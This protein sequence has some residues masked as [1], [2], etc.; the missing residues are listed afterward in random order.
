MPVLAPRPGACLLVAAWLLAAAQHDDGEGS[1][2]AGPAG[3]SCR[4]NAA[5]FSWRSFERCAIPAGSEIGEPLLVTVEEAKQRCGDEQSCTGFTFEGHDPDGPLSG[6]AIWVHLKSS[7]D[8]VDASWVAWRK[9]ASTGTPPA[10]P[11]TP[12]VEIEGTPRH[13]G[14]GEGQ[15]VALCLLGQVR[16]L[17]TTHFAMEQNMLSVLKPDVF[18]YGPK[19][20]GDDDEGG[21]ELYSLKD[22][23]VDA[24][25]EVEDIR[26]SL[27]RETPGAS[28]VIDLEYVEVQG[29]WFGNQC[30]DP[31]LRDNRP[32]SAICKYWSEHKCLQMIQDQEAQRGQQYAWVGISRFDFRWVAP[33]PPV[34]LLEGRDA[35]WIPSGSDWEGGINDRHALMPRKHAEVYLGAWKSVTTGNAKDVMLE[36]LGAMKVNGYPGPNTECFLRARLEYHDIDVE[37]FPSV[38]Y[39]TCTQRSK[40]RWTQCYGT[41][42]NDNPGWLYKDEMEHA[43][44][45]AKCV[46]ASWSERK[47]QDCLEDISY[48]YRGIR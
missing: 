31:P 8:C 29:N 18:L 1:C 25:W 45:V 15:G 48:L 35:V 47:M 20:P 22:Y 14:S 12:R 32:G 41:A 13:L 44:R 37:R 24:R 4:N 9:V 23:V 43:T 6:A 46:R 39:L 3:E 11:A 42:T 7:F 21:P 33:H 36:T 30:L 26:T 5:R 17:E 34:E 19:R 2:P 10:P 28:R 40:S 38:A 16:M 27:Y